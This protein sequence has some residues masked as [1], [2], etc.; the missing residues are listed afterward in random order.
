MGVA[1]GVGSGQQTRT[2][3]KLFI[4]SFLAL[5][6]EVVVIRYLST[7]IRVFA[8]FKNLPLISSFLGLGLGMAMGSPP[9]V[10]K[11]LF[12]LITAT[13][14]LLMAFAPTLHLSHVP[15]PGEDYF[16]FGQNETIVTH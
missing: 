11:R 10:L 16:L 8:Y 14:F 15:A 13:L 1:Y 4:A 2:T 7:E 9:K 12:P 3:V 5:Y 6:F